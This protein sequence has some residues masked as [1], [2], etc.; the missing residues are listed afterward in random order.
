MG[1]KRAHLIRLLTLDSNALLGL[2]ENNG[3]IPVKKIERD[4]SLGE[5]SIGKIAVIQDCLNQMEERKSIKYDMI[6]DLDITSPLRTVK[7]LEEVIQ[8][9]IEKK[10]MLQR[11]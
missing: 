9:Q 2:L 6:I 8:K 7:N 5:D 11:L 3:M 10:L 4:I 1:K